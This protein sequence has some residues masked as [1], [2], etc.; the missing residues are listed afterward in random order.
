MFYFILLLYSLYCERLI[1][2]PPFLFDAPTWCVIVLHVSA[3]QNH[4]CIHMK[5]KAHKKNY[6]SNKITKTKCNCCNRKIDCIW[7]L[8]YNLTRNGQA[9]Y[10]LHIF[11]QATTCNKKRDLWLLLLLDF[12]LAVLVKGKP[13]TNS[14]RPVIIT[15]LSFC[16]SEWVNILFY[17]Y[18]NFKT[19]QR[20]DL[21]FKLYVFVK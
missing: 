17:L 7:W 10:I 4:N 12:S 13:K 5:K 6:R 11:Y 21:Y 20:E 1:V 3:G 2:Y 14:Q 19:Y 8:M 9:T 16:Y 18:T 15:C